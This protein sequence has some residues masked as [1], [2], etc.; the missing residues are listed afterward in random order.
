MLRFTSHA[1]LA[2]FLLLVLLSGTARAQDGSSDD[3]R[4]RWK[5]RKQEEKAHRDALL[6]KEAARKEELA[7]MG[8]VGVETIGERG[9]PAGCVDVVF[10]GDGF[11]AD[12]MDT[13]RKVVAR[14]AENYA[15]PPFDT[16]TGRVNLHRIDLVSKDSG[17]AT[18]DGPHDTPLGGTVIPFPGG[19]LLKCDVKRAAEYTAAAVPGADYVQVVLNTHGKFLGSANSGA[20]V[21]LST[22]GGHQRSIVVHEFAHNFAGLLDEYVDPKQSA[23][24]Q[25][26]PRLAKVA[27]LSLLSNVHLTKWHLWNIPEAIFVGRERKKPVAPEDNVRCYEGAATFVDGVYR[28]EENCH[29]QRGRG[30][31]FCRVCRESLELCMFRF[32]TPIA[33]MDPLPAG[34]VL[35]GGRSR[36][37]RIRPIE[38]GGDDDSTEVRWY[39]DGRRL[40]A[41]GKPVVGPKFSLTGSALEPGTHHLTAVVDLH[42]PR[43]RV[44]RGRMSGAVTW[45]VTVVPDRG[46][47]GVG[48]RKS[49]DAGA[50]FTMSVPE[51][52]VPRD[53]PEGAEF[54]ETSRSLTWTPE[55]KHQGAWTLRFAA[56]TEE[57]S[58]EEKIFLTVKSPGKKRNL[59]PKLLFLPDQEGVEGETLTFTMP[60][61]DPD[62]DHLAWT[63]EGLPPGARFD[64]NSGE[65]IWEVRHFQRGGYEIEFDATDGFK[66]V[67]TTVRVKIAGRPLFRGIFRV[68]PAAEPKYEMPGDRMLVGL[69][70]FLP[71]IR[72]RSATATEGVPEPQLLAES[73]RLFREVA[74][75]ISAAAAE[76]LTSIF[77]EAAKEG[78]S[79]HLDM[80]LDQMPRYVWQFVDRPEDLVRIRRWLETALG[81]EG[82]GPSRQAKKDLEALLGDLDRIEKY[83][84]DRKEW[85]APPP[86][87]DKKYR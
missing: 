20:I 50:L 70:H 3:P 21:L 42:T 78:S 65:F 68:P 33:G 60:G 1:R 35:E 74:P 87:T 71:A 39:L 19:K 7:A 9:D 69:H 63:A 31:A 16:H 24:R 62:G 85:P 10:I 48:V 67:G 82:D 26:D 46:R 40:K 81:I 73:L 49:C 51:G 15:T 53:L 23:K 59:T 47:F 13:Y 18:G 80:F 8:I 64:P 14:M 43:V 66:R 4:Q 44:D 2:V 12:E 41:R 58:R 38:F 54:A 83:N 5:N 56:G 72:L 30:K 86:I 32:F 6:A 52:W 45:T 25:P 57:G 27:N 34:V 29:M 36:E 11:A 55:Q 76:R 17:I 77:D 61:W 37:F 22:A 79:W 75:R 28:A 84:R